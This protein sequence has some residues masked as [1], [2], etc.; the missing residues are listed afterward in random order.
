MINYDNRR[1]IAVSNTDN[2]ETSSETIFHYKQE[3]NILTAHYA[4]GKI[5]CGHL[6]GLVDEQGHID[7]RYH[8]MNKEDQLMTGRCQST[9]EVLPNGKI[10][11]HEQWQWT[12]GDCSSG[13]SI[14]EEME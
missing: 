6:L 12:S 2:G 10:R 13:T 5:V 8:Q 9:P 7:I 4:G 11:L 3:N 1:F 14:I